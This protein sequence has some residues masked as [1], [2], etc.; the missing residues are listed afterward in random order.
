[1]GE[2][3]LNAERVLPPLKPPKDLAGALVQLLRLMRRHRLLFV[4]LAS[5]HRYPAG[6]EPDALPGPIVDRATRR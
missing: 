2:A 3:Q 6:D 4:Y 5:A 1:M